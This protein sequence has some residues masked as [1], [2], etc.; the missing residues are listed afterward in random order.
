VD[1]IPKKGK[2]MGVRF[3]IQGLLPPTEKDPDPRYAFEMFE[4]CEY[5]QFRLR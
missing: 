2:E 1:L 4:S 3:W 5:G